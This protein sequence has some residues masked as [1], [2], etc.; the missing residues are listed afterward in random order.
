MDQTVAQTRLVDQRRNAQL[1]SRGNSYGEIK[2]N[3]HNQVLAVIRASPPLAEKNPDGNAICYYG[4]GDYNG[5]QSWT[6]NNKT[7]E[8]WDDQTF[9]RG[10]HAYHFRKLIR[11]TFGLANFHRCFSN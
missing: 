3:R 4:D 6:A 2:S 10:K 1:D 8:R 11:S 7:C 5:M 9:P